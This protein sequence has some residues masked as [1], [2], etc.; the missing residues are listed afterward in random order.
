MFVFPVVVVINAIIGIRVVFVL[1]VILA[2]LANFAF[3]VVLARLILS[4]I[5]VPGIAAVLDV[6]VLFLPIVVIFR[7]LDSFILV[8]FVLLCWCIFLV[9]DIL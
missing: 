6:F 9:F 8:L 2:V 1:L 4:V 3:L 5:R 7:Q